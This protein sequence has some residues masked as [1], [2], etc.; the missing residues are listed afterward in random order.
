VLAGYTVSQV[1]ESGFQSSISLENTSVRPAPV[2]LVLVFPDGVALSA[3]PECWW[4]VVCTQSGN[5]ITLVT[6]SPLPPG[7]RRFI[8]F[9]AGR[10]PGPAPFEPLECTVNGSA[11][12]GF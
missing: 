12:D 9:N 11:C 7:A 3:R 10:S 2:V 8:G 1:W 4:D 6:T 5:T